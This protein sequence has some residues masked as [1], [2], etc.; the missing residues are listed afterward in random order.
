M[1]ILRN[2]IIN[3]NN[4]SIC[5]KASLVLLNILGRSE[6][7][8]YCNTKELVNEEQQFNL[9]IASIIAKE[10]KISQISLEQFFKFYEGGGS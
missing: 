1:R 2:I 10:G 5:Y 7:E 9:H 3:T 4:V 8:E 6:L